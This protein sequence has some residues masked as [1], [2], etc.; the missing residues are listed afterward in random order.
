MP[1]ISPF[2]P[3]SPFFKVSTHNSSNPSLLEKFGFD[4]G[5]GFAKQGLLTLS[6]TRD[7]IQEN[8]HFDLMRKIEFLGPG[9]R[10]YEMGLWLFSTKKVRAHLLIRL[11]LFF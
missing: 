1:K 4:K 11:H 5:P 6:K 2:L 8:P 7:L 9:Q 3:S 10:K